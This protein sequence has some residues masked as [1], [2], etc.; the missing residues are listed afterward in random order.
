MSFL[1][2]LL[3]L[4]F[5]IIIRTLFPLVIALNVI[6]DVLKSPHL[7]LHSFPLVL[8]PLL[9]LKLGSLFVDMLLQF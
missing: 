3:I 8:D 2:V 9:V 4:I 1:L 6:K 7:F 5:F